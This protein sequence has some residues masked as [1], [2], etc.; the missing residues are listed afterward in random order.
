LPLNRYGELTL[1]RLGGIESEL[2]QR[3]GLK[4]GHFSSFRTNRPWY[5]RARTII[6]LVFWPLV[7]ATLF[8][9]YKF[10]FAAPPIVPPPAPASGVRSRSPTPQMGN[11]QFV[12]G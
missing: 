10:S 6:H 9:T 1:E 8:Q 11:D 7:A 2:N 3:F 4:L 12:D 5:R